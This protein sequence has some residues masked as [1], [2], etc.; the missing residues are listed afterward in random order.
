MSDLKCWYVFAP[1]EM[2]GFLIL[3]RTRGQARAQYADFHDLMYQ[4][5]IDF[6]I[7]ARRVPALDGITEYPTI[8]LDPDPYILTGFWCPCWDCEHPVLRWNYYR[9]DEEFA[10]LLDGA[11]Y[12][13]ECAVAY[14]GYGDLAI[15]V[16]A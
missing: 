1:V 12:C 7:G 4:E 14:L 3:D 10:I 15:G 8:L 16:E 2:E 9:D 13:P 6:R 5:V 11:V